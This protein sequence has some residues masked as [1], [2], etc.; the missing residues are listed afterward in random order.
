VH[1]A[2]G[3]SLLSCLQAEIRATEFLKPPSWIFAYLVAAYYHCYDTRGVSAH[4]YS[5]VAVRI[6]FL[7]SVEQ[8]IYHALM[9]FSCSPAIFR[10]SDQ[11][12]FLNS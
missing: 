8:E 10:K 2:V 6:L 12:V 7:A 11:N 1:V 4:K 5:D 9:F 3:I